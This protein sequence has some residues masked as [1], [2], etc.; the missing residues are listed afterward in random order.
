LSHGAP[1]LAAWLCAG[2]VQFSWSRESRHAP[3]PAE[4]VAR[5]APRTTELGDCLAAFG[6]PLWAWEHV[7]G[8]R[9]GAAL[10]YGWSDERSLGLRVTVN[11]YRGVSASVDYDQVDQ[12]M[13]GLVLF[14]DQ[15]WRL[16]S[17][18]EGL[19]LDL[20]REARRP[21]AAVDDEEGAGA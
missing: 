3:V 15:D 6:A 11:V 10:A 17:W 18:R 16:T 8:G 9:P 12:R 21:P 7:E 20:T 2:C 1:F 4:A 14:F 5:L 13:R 19:L